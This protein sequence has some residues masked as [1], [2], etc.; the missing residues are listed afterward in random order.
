MTAPKKKD[1]PE[2]DPMG[3]LPGVAGSVLLSDQIEF[4][5]DRNNLD[6]PLIENFGSENLK[7]ARYNLR[8]GDEAHIEGQ[9]VRIDDD[10]PLI[11]QPHQVAVVKNQ[12]AKISY[13]TLESQG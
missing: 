4:Y 3:I 6:P 5:C 7:P 8:L 10:P 2:S 9:W 12:P 11:L 13:R 1:P